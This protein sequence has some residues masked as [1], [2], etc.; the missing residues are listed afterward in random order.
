[1]ETYTSEAEYLRA[2]QG[3]SALPEGFVAGS[4]E[5]RFMPGEIEAPE[6]Y[7]MNL[8]ALV[9]EEPT[10]SFAGVFTRNAYPGAPVLV[11]RDRMKEPKIRG[12]IINNKISNVCV[13]TGIR[14]SE[15]VCE[16]AAGV[17]GGSAEQFLPAST[18]IIGWRLPVEELS[19]NM[20][21]LEASVSRTG[22]LDVAK[23][24]MTTDAFPKIRRA[25]LAGGASIVGTCKGAGMIEPNMGTMLVFIMTDADLP[26]GRLGELLRDAVNPSFNAISIDGDQST[27]DTALILS[28]RRKPPP[29]EDQFAEALRRVCVEL[30]TDLVRNGEGT[31][32]VIRCSVHGAPD[33]Q[34][35]RGAAKAVINSS[36]VKTAIF[37]NDPN[38]GRII[39][40]LGDYLGTTAEGEGGRL[41]LASSVC[42]PAAIS[43]GEEIVFSEGAFR[44]DPQKERRIHSYL[45]NAAAPEVPVRFPAHDRTVDISVD[46][47]IGEGTF[48]AMGSDLSYDYVRENAEYRT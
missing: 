19:A 9:A 14:D 3:R 7:R 33:E 21:A 23:G 6:P 42:A 32:H 45:E 40:A 24:I 48:T 31:S 36:L 29:R 16:A 26:G 35:A 46:L 10:D 5:F 25:D 8:S 18:G 1:M 4:T 43:I 13:A 41:C 37:G 17:F 20:K 39:M 47:G 38:V 30:A 44:I 34:I 2:V 22:L 27:S 28:S 11:C 15:T 12:I